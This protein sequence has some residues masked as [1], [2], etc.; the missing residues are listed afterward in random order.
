MNNDI[1]KLIK[2]R[3]DLK[4]LT[5]DYCNSCVEI[6]KNGKISEV[7]ISQST[8]VSIVTNFGLVTGDMIKPFEDNE[9]E[10]DVS[11]KLTSVIYEKTVELRN[12]HIQKLI[13]NNPD[14]ALINDSSILL[15]SNVTIT[16]FGNPSNKFNLQNFCIFTSEIL[17]F[18]FGELNQG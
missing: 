10:L 4:A 12:E 9:K 8:Q 18:T 7:S 3:I 6:L 2:D 17:G 16:P 13:D 11:T 5:Y 1:P 14:V 15:L